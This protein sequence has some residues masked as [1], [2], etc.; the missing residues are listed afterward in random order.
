[1]NYGREVDETFQGG[2][3]ALQ[4]FLG[5]IQ[6]AV[7]FVASKPWIM[8]LVLLLWLTSGK[9][10]LKLGKFLDLKMG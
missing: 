5:F 8:F 2:F 3:D 9:T 6:R 7:Y 1:M 10:G 4:S